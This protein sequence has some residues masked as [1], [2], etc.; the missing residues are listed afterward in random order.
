M[1]QNAQRAVKFLVP[2]LGAARLALPGGTG[3]PRGLRYAAAG[4]AGGGLGVS[5]AGSRGT[6]RR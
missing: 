5:R 6:R 1:L 4:G 3:A 2:G